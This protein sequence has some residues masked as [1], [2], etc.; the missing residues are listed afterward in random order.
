MIIFARHSSFTTS[1][2]TLF[3]FA[4]PVVRL[5]A[6]FIIPN[7]AAL[8]TSVLTDVKSR[9]LSRPRLALTIN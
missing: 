1:L 6:T 8:F 2:K 9:L 5:V 3:V 7:R 4:M